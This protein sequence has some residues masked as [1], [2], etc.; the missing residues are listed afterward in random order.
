MATASVTNTFV[1]GT[2][3]EAAEVNTNFTNLVTFLNNSVVHQ[4]GSKAMTANFDAGTN[5][6]VNLT[7]GTAAT[8]AVNKTQ[9]D[10]AVNNSAWTA[11]TPTVS[12]GVS[13]NIA[14]TVNYS[15][16]ARIGR[17]IIWSFSLS[18]TGT[19]TAGSGLRITLPVAAAST[20]GIG[21]S[22]IYVDIGSLIYTVEYSGTSTSQ[23]GLSS[24]GANDAFGVSPSLAPAV[25][26]GMSGVIIYEAAS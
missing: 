5:K 3:A 23:V 9:L 25:G 1:A 16:Y 7:A 20:S 8:D 22:G 10:A 18:F 19:G 12:Q 4:D 15:K 21:G 6:I 24:S 17:L 26:D 2:A 13:T 11:Y 14:K